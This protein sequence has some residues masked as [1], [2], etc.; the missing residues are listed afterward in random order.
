MCILYVGFRQVQKAKRLAKKA[1]ANAKFDK[2]QQKGKGKGR[3][4]GKGRGKGRGKQKAKGQQTEHEVEEVKAED[5]DEDAEGPKVK[6][7]L[8]FDDKAEGLAPSTPEIVGMSPPGTPEIF[9]DD[10]GIFGDSVGH[11]SGDKIDDGKEDGED[12][13]SPSILESDHEA[14][15]MVPESLEPCT[16]EPVAEALS[17]NPGEQS[18]DPMVPLRDGGGGGGPSGPRGPNQHHT[19]STLASI[20]PPGASILLN[21][22]LPQIAWQSL[23]TNDTIATNCFGKI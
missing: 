14:D 17:E 1:R 18:G 2:Q 20:S 9:G 6:R 11:V 5:T 4:L 12:C 19:P 16:L 23:T 10:S 21:C 3:G 22:V 8:T 13:Y 15:K 7:R